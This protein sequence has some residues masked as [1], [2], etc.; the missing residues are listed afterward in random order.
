MNR[1]RKFIIFFNYAIYSQILKSH[2]VREMRR[3]LK[4]Q[5]S[6]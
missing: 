5:Q 3:N 2:V 4:Y 1:Q 6:I